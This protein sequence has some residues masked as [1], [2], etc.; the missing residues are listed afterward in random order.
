[1]PNC[2]PYCLCCVARQ[3]EFERL[4]NH[5]VAAQTELGVVRQRVSDVLTSCLRPQTLTNNVR[6]CGALMDQI[7]T[8]VTAVIDEVR[9]SKVIGS[10]LQ[11]ALDLCE[12]GKNLLSIVENQV[13]KWSLVEIWLHTHLVMYVTH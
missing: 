5:M 8:K 7:L 10:R 9:R 3:E 6:T 1:M 2:R 11:D 12:K 4:T 13:G